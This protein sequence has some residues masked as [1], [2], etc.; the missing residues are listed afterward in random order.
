MTIPKIL[1]A[2]AALLLCCGAGGADTT[3]IEKPAVLFVY[4]TLD[5]DTRFYVETFRD[6]L[7]E[8]G[9]GFEEAAVEHAVDSDPAP[10]DYLVIYSRVMAFDLASPVR[11]WLRSLN[12]LEGKKVFLFVTAAKWLHE[13]QRN[14][15]TEIVRKRGGTVVDAVSSAT[16]DM[17]EEQ[18]REKIERHLSGLTP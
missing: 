16:S 6:Y 9:R 8:S 5:D 14:N 10:F 11:K 15:L 1:G 17:S 12:A 18:K 13:K 7:K 3:S 4:D 2:A